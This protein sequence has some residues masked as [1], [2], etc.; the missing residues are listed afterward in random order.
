MHVTLWLEPGAGYLGTDCDPVNDVAPIAM[1]QAQAHKYT[2]KQA[3][4]QAEI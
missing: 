3:Q 1:S 2:S 4:V